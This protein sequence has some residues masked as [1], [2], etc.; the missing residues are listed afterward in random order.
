MN[1]SPFYIIRDF[2]S[3]LEC[4]D[5]IDRSYFDF[6]NT[7]NGIP[8][9]SITSNILTQNRIL[10]YLEDAIPALESYYDFTHAGI[11]PFSIECYPALSKQETVRSENS[12]HV[13]GRWRRVN[14]NDF[15][16]IIF[17]KENGS[18]VNFDD[19]FEIYGSKLEFPSHNFGFN[20]ARGML[21][22]FPSAPNFIN[23]TTPPA[24]GDAYQIRFQIVAS[25][26]YTYDMSKFQGNYTT[27]F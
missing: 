25:E 1:K 27:W 21:V 23:A 14:D 9:K 7:E 20:P 24:V 16:G 17:L 2:L 13:E 8:V 18:D 12:Q 10:P 3:P 26:P 22:V 4:E 6:P 19:E 5:I 15:T 11:L